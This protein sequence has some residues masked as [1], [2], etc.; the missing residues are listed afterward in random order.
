M[1]KTL[2]PIIGLEIHIELKT[3]S[4]MFCGC[5][6]DPFHADEPNTHTCM[7]CLGLPG[8]LPVANKTAIEWTAMFGSA[9]NCQ[10]SPISEFSRKHYQYPD[11][12]KGYQISQYD[13][14][15]CT[16]GEI[17]VEEKLVGITRVHLEEDTA[18]MSHTTIDEKAVSLLDFNRSG[19]PLLEMVTEPCLYSA[20]EAGD[21][22]R[23]I[24][25]IATALNISDANMEQGSMRLE[26]NI[27]LTEKAGELPNYKVE[28]KNINS[29]R[30]L[31]Q[32]IEYELKRQEALLQDGKTPKQE[33]RGW[34]EK[35]KETIAQRSKETAEDYR[36]FPDPD[37]PPVL[38][39]TKVIESLKEQ[40]QKGLESATFSHKSL[41]L[42]LGLNDSLTNAVLKRNDRD[43]AIALLQSANDQKLDLKQLTLLLL[44]DSTISPDTLDQ[45]KVQLNTQLETLSAEDLEPLVHQILTDKPHLLDEIKN[46]KQ[47]AIGVI[48][49]SCIAQLKQQ[50]KSNL[51]SAEIAKL[52]TEIVSRS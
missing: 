17:Q 50:G 9:L 11:L 6:N 37:L 18:K 35:K 13:K 36:Y 40:A 21:L 26:A 38:L 23:K 27:S 41:L 48:I 42:S 4:K 49:G 47:Q 20:K 29:F 15:L 3:K 34:N 8:G 10:I 32:A 19:V 22:A 28:V 33:T 16:N 24:R 51:D 43:E 45:L 14:P 2:S 44:K 46:G 7:V 1:S 31:E 30:Y 12:P 52:I 39:S 25:D 5:K